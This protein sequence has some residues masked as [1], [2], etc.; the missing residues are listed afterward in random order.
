MLLQNNKNIFFIQTTKTGSVKSVKALLEAK[1][2]VTT[3]ID[4]FQKIVFNRFDFFF[5]Y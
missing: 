4:Y 5:N 1:A 3:K 2:N